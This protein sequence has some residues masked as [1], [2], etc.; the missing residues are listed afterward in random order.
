[1]RPPTGRATPRT[2]RPTAR[3]RS[4]SPGPHAP[5]RASVL[6]APRPPARPVARARPVAKTHASNA[7]GRTRPVG[8]AAP[9]GTRTPARAPSPRLPAR[10]GS[11]EGHPTS[12]RSRAASTS[13]ALRRGRQRSCGPP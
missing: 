7:S 13:R 12:A 10:S 9:H 1:V 11:S 3:L 6:R 8:S 5:G 2:T 4:P